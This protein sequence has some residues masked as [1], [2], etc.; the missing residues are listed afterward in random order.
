MSKTERVKKPVFGISGLLGKH[1]IEEVNTTDLLN[2]KGVFK[3]LKNQQTI[4]SKEI[5]ELKQTINILNEQNREQ[6]GKIIRYE[7]KLKLN[8]RMSIIYLFMT[9]IGDAMIGYVINKLS[10]STGFSTEMVI[11][12]S[13]GFILNIAGPTISYFQK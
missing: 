8:N 10:D 11:I 2:G 3:I 7:E 4:S 5:E 1:S 13:I 9:I 12:A 6:Y